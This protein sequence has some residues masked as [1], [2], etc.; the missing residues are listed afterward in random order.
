MTRNWGD[1]KKP[2]ARGNG[3]DIQRIKYGNET[4]V[5]LV[6][7]VLPRYVYWV[8][9]TEGKRVPLEC[10]SFD[11]S[12]EQFTSKYPDPFNEVDKD[13]YSDNATFSYVCNAID[14]ADGEIK[15]MDLK[16]TVYKQ[17]IDYATNPDYGDPAD[18]ETGYDIIIK[19]EKTGPL[20][21]N[22]KYSVMPS[23]SNVPLTDEEKEMEL[24][25]LDTIFKRPEYDTQKEWLL[26]NTTFF[27]DDVSL[28]LNSTEDMQDI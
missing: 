7:E 14:R 9:T 4:R 23:R 11:R 22:V 2:Q 6:G 20:P 5:R 18:P 25:S 27:A 16:T 1:L 19:K 26:K 10:I 17:I 21:Q 15:L 13:A 12:T 28:E 3:R 8:T 24:F